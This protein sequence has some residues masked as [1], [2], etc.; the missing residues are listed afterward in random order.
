MLSMS[1]FL[2]YDLAL[3]IMLAFWRTEKDANFGRRKF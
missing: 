2:S 3:V 1:S